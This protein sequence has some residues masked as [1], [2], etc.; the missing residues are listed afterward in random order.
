MCLRSTGVRILL[1]FEPL[2]LTVGQFPPPISKI[3]E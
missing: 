1:A 2:T 3:G